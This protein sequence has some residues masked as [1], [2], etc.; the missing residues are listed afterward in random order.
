MVVIRATRKVLRVGSGSLVDF[1]KTTSFYLPIRDWDDFSLL[2]VED[3]L[4]ETPCRAG[5]SFA[6]TIFPNL[7]VPRL[8]QT[9]WG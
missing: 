3:R 5:G 9:K 6:T 2:E 1:A 7:A 8:L 4:A